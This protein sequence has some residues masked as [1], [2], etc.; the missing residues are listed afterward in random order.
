MLAI[1]FGVFTMCQFVP[2]PINHFSKVGILIIPR[3]IY[4]ATRHR[5]FK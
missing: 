5:E 1:V 2:R 3:F 4:D